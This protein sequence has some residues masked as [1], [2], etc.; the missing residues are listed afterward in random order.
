MQPAPLGRRS[1]P[2]DSVAQLGAWNIQD[3]PAGE[4]AAGERSHPDETEGPR[5][6]G[7]PPRSGRR[8]L[9][10]GGACI[11][12]AFPTLSMVF[13]TSMTAFS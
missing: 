9:G 2:D 5:D 13:T 12:T 1:A 6:H 11:P 10:H 3:L 4:T 7:G 8:T